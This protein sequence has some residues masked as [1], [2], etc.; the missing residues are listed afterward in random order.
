MTD[1]H[2]SM[3]FNTAPISLRQ[4]L[5]YIELPET[6]L[7]TALSTPTTEQ[8][9]SIIQMNYLPPASRTEAFD[10][11]G[12]CHGCGT[13]KTHTDLITFECSLFEQ[14]NAYMQEQFTAQSQMRDIEE[15]KMPIEIETRGRAAAKRRRDELTGEKEELDKVIS[16]AQEGLKAAEVSRVAAIEVAVEIRNDI[17]ELHGIS[18]RAEKDQWIQGRLQKHADEEKLLRT[19]AE[20]LFGSNW[21]ERFAA[22]SDVRELWD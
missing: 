8:A 5:M 13:S 15:Q 16:M 17:K 14:L 20:A 2:W 11:F 21:E 7:Q 19:Q 22:Q 18:G 1:F 3:G 6:Q 10:E 12:P 9:L 4:L